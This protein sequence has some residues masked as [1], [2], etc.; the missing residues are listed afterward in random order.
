MAV[1]RGARTEA[2]RRQGVGVVAHLFGVT[3]PG[4]LQSSTDSAIRS[5]GND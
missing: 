2:A 5:G 3:E 4:N 1:K